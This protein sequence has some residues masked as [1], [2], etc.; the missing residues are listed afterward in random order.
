MSKDLKTIKEMLRWRQMAA[1]RS[2]LMVRLKREMFE[3]MQTHLE[4]VTELIKVNSNQLSQ[5]CKIPFYENNS[6]I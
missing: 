2:T 5:L 1:A 4:V 6:S 3:Q